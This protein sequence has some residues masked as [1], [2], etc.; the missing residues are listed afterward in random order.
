MLENYC[1]DYNY[2][3]YDALKTIVTSL[4]NQYEP[5]EKLL[6]SELITENYC[7]LLKIC[8]GPAAAERGR[9][10]IGTTLVP[11]LP[12]WSPIKLHHWF[13]LT[14]LQIYTSTKTG[15]DASKGETRLGYV[16]SKF[17]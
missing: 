13:V 3:A 2:I 14:L 12:G 7:F 17:V 11:G 10:L 1:M 6:I 15:A 5:I 8:V 4:W 9:T 16:D